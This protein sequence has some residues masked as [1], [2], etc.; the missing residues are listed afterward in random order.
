[1]C[2]VVVVAREGEGRRESAEPLGQKLAK[3]LLCGVWCCSVLS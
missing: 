1:M 3:E 2:M